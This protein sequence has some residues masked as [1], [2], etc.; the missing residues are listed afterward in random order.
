MGATFSTHPC[1]RV[2]DKKGPGRGS[3]F[4]TLCSSVA[5]IGFGL[6]ISKIGKPDSGGQQIKVGSQ[7]LVGQERKKKTQKVPTS[8]VEM[9]NFSSATNHRHNQLDAEY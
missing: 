8:T 7:E 6:R 2:G 5:D 3:P 1:V 4:R 9:I